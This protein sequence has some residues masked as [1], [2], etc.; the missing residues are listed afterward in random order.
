MQ[1]LDF[2]GVGSFVFESFA[3]NG[4]EN[5]ILCDK[6]TVD[7]TNL[8]RQLVAE[9]GNIG[10][11]KSE[12]AKELVHRVNSNVK[13]YD[14]Y[15]EI[16]DYS[17]LEK[18]FENTFY[19]NYIIDAVDDINAKIMI[20]RYATEKGIK[21][22][23]STGAAQKTKP[24]MVKMDKIYNTKNCPLGKILR[25]RLKDIE[26]EERTKNNRKISFKNVYSIYS[27]EIPQKSQGVNKTLMEV[28]S[29]YGIFIAAYVINDIC[30]KN[31]KK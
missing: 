17:D 26:K 12:V 23:T 1:Y 6:D 30:G 5:M 19:P 11:K 31:N 2:G 9:T 10:R 4:V 27:E 25:K 21:I 29:T 16:R 24:W 3:R 22:I 13:V 28:T 15:K 8:N 7:V 18:I 20:I 14:I